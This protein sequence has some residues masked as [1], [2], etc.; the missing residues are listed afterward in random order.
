MNAQ[1][2]AVRTVSEDFLTILNSG[3]TYALDRELFGQGP[4]NRV[5]LIFEDEFQPGEISEKAA[6]KL[7]KIT[8]INLFIKDNVYENRDPQLL[9][10]PIGGTKNLIVYNQMAEKPIRFQQIKELSSNFSKDSTENLCFIDDNHIL[11]CGGNG[12]SRD[13][14]IYNLFLGTL[15]A[16][17]PMLFGHNWH[18]CIHIDDSVYVFGSYDGNPRACE[19]YKI[20]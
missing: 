7:Q 11:I 16:K 13:T 9:L 19:Y 2:E 12:P 8:G 4:T 14:S 3:K 10:Y 6:E 15:A 5:K 18:A 1:M 17:Q 20:Q